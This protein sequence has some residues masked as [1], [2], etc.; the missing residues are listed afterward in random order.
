MYASY[1]YTLPTLTERLGALGWQGG[2][3]TDLK[4]GDS[5]KPVNAADRGP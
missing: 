3:V 1:H 4:S 5:E 2:K